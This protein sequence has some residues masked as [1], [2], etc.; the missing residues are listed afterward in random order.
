MTTAASVQRFRTAVVRRLGLWFDDT[1][2]D[3]L[4]EVL[5]NAVP[6]ARD[7]S[8]F[9]DRLEAGTSPRAEVRA[10]ADALTI[11][12]T[13]FF[14]NVEQFD[15]LR[16]VALPAIARARET[17]RRVRVISAGCSSGEEPYSLAI[18]V[19]EYFGA[20]DPPWTME[21][22]G[23][24][25]NASSLARAKE[26]RYTKWS[27]RAM[28]DTP[29]TQWFRP[30][31]TGFE[32][33]D[34]IRSMV[35]FVERNLLDDDPILWQPQ[36]YDVVFCRNVL[37]YFAP[38][39]SRRILT[40]LVG[41]LAPGG[42]L[43]LGHAE[44]LRGLGTALELRNTHGTFYYRR[45]TDAAQPVGGVWM[46]EGNTVAGSTDATHAHREAPW[47]D[48]IDAAAS[49]VRSL[50]DTE[51][52]FHANA[53]TD[54]DLPRFVAPDLGPALPT[55]DDALAEATA[56]LQRERY[57]DALAVLDGLPSATSGDAKVRLLRAVLLTHGGRLA[58]AELT[59]RSLL[60]TGGNGAEAHF[61]LALCAERRGDPSNAGDHDRIAIHLDAGFAMPR[62]H[63]GLMARRRGDLDAA[64]RE[65]GQALSLLHGEPAARL[66]LFGGGFGRDA[67]LSIAKAEL[68]ASGGR[69]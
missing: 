54:V 36:S 41:S 33:D 27:L 64:R 28:S 4:D 60:D 53:S 42:W 68:V 16:E 23:V 43:F 11:G 58:E 39:Q 6:S 37:M 61:L 34:G 69:S 7:R 55:P 2:L 18:A 48:Q 19:R 20:K 59:C 15:A 45:S 1:R 32:L 44:S 67:L 26:G 13:Y 62:L 66:L 49:R 25:I 10:L 52:P 46:R 38:E 3:F 31:G 9:L 47:F 35:D 17:V 8:E 40:R 12:E 56:L 14:R 63:L 51:R 30:S 24:D 29:A 21:V 5:N 65:L 22:R 50:I 57:I